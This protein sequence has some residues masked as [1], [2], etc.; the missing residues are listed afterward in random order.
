MKKTRKSAIILT[1]LLLTALPTAVAYAETDDFELPSP[2]WAPG[3]P[4]YGLEIFIENNIEIPLARMTRGQIGEAEKRLQLAEERLAELQEVCN[5][6]DT[7]TLERLRQRYEYHIFEAQALGNMTDSLELDTLL[8]NRTM[9]HVRV[10][11]QLSAHVS[12]QGRQGVDMALKSSTESFGRQM[13]RLAERIEQEDVNGTRLQLHIETL[14]SQVQERLNQWQQIRENMPSL[15]QDVD[16]QMPI[17]PLGKINR[18]HRG[19][20]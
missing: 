3:H 6:S 7:A 5:R 19:P 15:G 8:G 11:T 10:L 9:N 14:Q 20:P 17:D 16:I 2:S 18:T 12:E 13:N 1:A 4:F